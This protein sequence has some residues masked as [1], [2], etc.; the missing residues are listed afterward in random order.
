[1][2]SKNFWVYKKKKKKKKHPFYFPKNKKERGTKGLFFFLKIKTKKLT[3]SDLF[4]WAFIYVKFCA[5][6]N[7]FLGAPKP[8]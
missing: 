7:I 1:M 8:V 6:K 3:F 2:G 4:L 5:I